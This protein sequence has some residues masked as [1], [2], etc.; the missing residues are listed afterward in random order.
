[1]KPYLTT[2]MICGD[3]RTEELERALTSLL[4]RGNLKPICDEIVVID[5]GTTG[6]VRRCVENF[7]L[8][9]PDVAFKTGTYRNPTGASVPDFAAARN[10]SLN[11]A[12]GE[13]FMWMDSDDVLPTSDDQKKE[14]VLF[15]PDVTPPETLEDL[16]TS[17]TIRPP[18]VWSVAFRVSASFAGPQVAGGG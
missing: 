6:E 1:M 17:L 3:G 4:I 15:N 7:G 5:C 16:K 14:I 11:L 10:L 9:Y 2:G 18:G 8:A 12:S 13:W